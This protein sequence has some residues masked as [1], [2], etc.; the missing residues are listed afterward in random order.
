MSQ[1]NASATC[2][3][4][5]RAVGCSVMRKCTTLR[6]SWARMISTNS[7]WKRTVDTVKKSSDTSSFVWLARNARHVGEG[8]LRGRT[9]YFSTVDLATSMPS[10]RSSLWMRGDPQEELARD[11]LRMRSRISSAMDDRPGVPGRLRRVQWWR[12]R[13]RCQEMTVMGLTKTRASCQ[14]DHALDSQTQSRR[15]AGLSRVMPEG[16]NLQLQG[17]ARAEQGDHGGGQGDEDSSHGGH[18][19]HAVRAAQR[20]RWRPSGPCRRLAGPSRVWKRVSISDRDPARIR[21]T[22]GT[23]TSRSHRRPAQS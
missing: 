18:A 12:N 4:V 14:P 15:S 2:W 3:A 1:G 13:L 6:R 7:T 5:Q 16:E 11:I 17:G 9:L 19:T 22:G 8:G 21:F 23:A 20:L 10:L